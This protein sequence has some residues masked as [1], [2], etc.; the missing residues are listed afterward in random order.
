MNV[1]LE[2]EYTKNSFEYD[3]NIILLYSGTLHM[4]V[5]FIFFFAF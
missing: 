1:Y 2:Y 3:L 4:H 5:M